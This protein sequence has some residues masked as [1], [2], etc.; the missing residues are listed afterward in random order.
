M[1]TSKLRNRII[2]AIAFVLCVA[3]VSLFIVTMVTV[4]NDAGKVKLYKNAQIIVSDNVSPTPSTTADTT[5]KV[6]KSVVSIK[7]TLSG[8]ISS[9]SGVIIGKNFNSSNELTGYF[10]ITNH[11]VIENGTSFVVTDIN[12]NN[13]NGTLVGGDKLTDIAVLKIDTLSDLTV[14]EIGNSQT[15]RRG[16]E[17]IVVGNMLGVYQ[18]SVSMGVISNLSSKVTFADGSV[19]NLIQTDAAV[20]GG[21]SGGG[22]F[23]MLGQLVGIVNAKTSSSS[24]DNIGFAIPVAEGIEVAQKLISTATKENPYGY[25]EGRTTLGFDVNVYTHIFYGNFMMVQSSSIS[26]VSVNDY[27]L[28]VTYGDKTLNFSN[29]DVSSQDLIDFNELVNSL[30]IGDSVTLELSSD[31]QTTK[32]VTVKAIQ[33]KYT[34]PKG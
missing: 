29:G 31:G 21:N 22:M 6:E 28:K 2:T 12:G 30:T 24:V 14:S 33:Y 25:V 11:H 3:I 18:G 10:I 4:D 34:P 16:E 9:G 17:V 19:R 1:Q 20:N 23:N 8:G 27:L 7:T 5:A 26:T 13:Y 32:S 15:L